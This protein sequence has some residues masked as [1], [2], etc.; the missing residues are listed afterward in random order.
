VYLQERPHWDEIVALYSL[1][2]SDNTVNGTQ[3]DVEKLIRQAQ[4]PVP[5]WKQLLRKVR[6]RPHSWPL[7]SISQ[8]SKHFLDL[9]CSTGTKLIEFAKRGYDVWGVDVDGDAIAVCKE[10]LPQGHFIQGEL[11][12]V[13][14]PSGYFDYIR[15]DNALEHMPNPREV[16]KACHR[17]LK[18]Q[19]QL[20]IYVP[21]GKS[22]SMRLMKGNSISS[23]IP[24]HLQLFTRKSIKH[25]MR[26]TG[27]NETKVYGYC[28]N[29]WLPLSIMQMKSRNKA[30]LNLDYPSWLQLCLYP[31]GWIASRVGLAEELVG[32]ARKA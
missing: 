8:G 14:L 24:F 28:A 2:S 10:L 9:G 26:N 30:S 7:E 32:I 13:D 27:F 17:L 5:K 11:L 22:L 23:W 19:G 18:D 15:I 29:S 20:L 1:S 3:V 12:E 21:H 4:L 6:F 16:I 25:L 31:V